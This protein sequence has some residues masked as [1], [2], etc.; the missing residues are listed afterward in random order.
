MKYATLRN[1]NNDYIYISKKNPGYYSH[2]EDKNIFDYE[3]R[4]EKYS[5]FVNTVNNINKDLFQ[6]IESMNP[7]FQSLLKDYLDNKSNEF[8]KNIVVKSYEIENPQKNNSVSI[9]DTMNISVLKN[10][11]IY[12]KNDANKN[13]AAYKNDANKYNAAYK[14]NVYMEVILGNLDEKTMGELNCQYKDKNLISRFLELMNPVKTY[15]I[16]KREPF[17]VET[18]KTEI[19][20]KKKAKEEKIQSVKSKTAKRG[21]MKTGGYTRRNR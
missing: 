21:Q 3:L 6:N 9:D 19:K 20:K 18:A 7:D 10:N 13:N 2:Y 14:I 12:N 8:Y 16:V 15:K 17:N 11:A 5:F 4:K 1:D